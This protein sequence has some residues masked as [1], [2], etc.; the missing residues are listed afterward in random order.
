MLFS[1]ERGG[2]F[3]YFLGNILEIV[4]WRDLLHTFYRQLQLP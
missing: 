1:L 3:C 2:L 4:I